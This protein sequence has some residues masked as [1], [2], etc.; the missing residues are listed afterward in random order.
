[1]KKDLV[2]GIVG[3]II[4]VAAMVGVFK[5]EAD[6]G[7]G[8]SW[9][10][11][12]TE[13]TAAGPT[14]DG[15]TQ[16][17]ATTAEELN[18]TASNLTRVTF[19]LRWTDAENQGRGAPD[20][21]NLTVAGPDGATNASGEASNGEI[22][23]TVEGLAPMPGELRLLAASQAEAESRIARDAT[24]T[25][26]QG[27]WSVFVRLVSA[28]GLAAPAGGVEVQ[29]DGVNAWTLETELVSFTPSFAQG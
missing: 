27:V 4:L 21:F 6:R 17:G 8:Q 28:P 18:V 3:T 1:M 12:W 11:T 9:A 26:G 15:T 29:A 5:Y 10:V 7:G 25:A 22:V 23:V 19:T 16:A 24:T 14:L 13:A 2:V 20:T